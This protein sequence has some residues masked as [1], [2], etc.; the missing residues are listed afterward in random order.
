[1]GKQFIIVM[2]VLVFLII[3]KVQSKVLAF[4]TFHP[5]SLPILLPRPFKLDTVERPFLKC[6][7]EEFEKSKERIE[8]NTLESTIKII[9]IF[10]KCVSGAPLHDLISF[11]A[12][13]EIRE[14]LSKENIIMY[15]VRD[16]YLQALI[17]Y[18]VSNFVKTFSYSFIYKNIHMHK[19]FNFK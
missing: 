2:M 18:M 17:F 12:M 14:C 8:R 19:N 10:G 6:I 1:M 16:C 11:K 13:E 15:G 9:A 3:V 5:S 4:T 7:E